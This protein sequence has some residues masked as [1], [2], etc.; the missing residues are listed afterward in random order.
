MAIQFHCPQCGNHIEV[1]DQWAL[2]DVACPFCRKTVNAP[3][4]STFPPDR[5]TPAAA[6]ILIDAAIGPGA[7]PARGGTNVVA[8]VALVLSC[9][10]LVTGMAS[11]MLIRPAVV[12]AL[13]QNPTPREMQDF[14]QDQLERQPP[15]SW[16]IAGMVSFL[17]SA[18]FWIAGLVCAIIGVGNRTRRRFALAAFA[19]LAL[20]PIFVCAGLATGI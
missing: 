11:P 16:L 6:P 19:V 10:W 12:D 7:A 9:L 5:D 15:A 13:G 4:Q 14:I 1:D 3:E 18:V 2:R 20:G 8:I 17:A